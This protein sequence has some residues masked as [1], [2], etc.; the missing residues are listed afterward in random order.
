MSS[1]S[2]KDLEGFTGIKAHTL[3][4]WEKRYHVLKPQR[5]STNIRTYDD[6]DLKRILNISILNRHGYRISDIIKLSEK[7]ICEKV[8]QLSQRCADTHSQIEN[9][10]MA[11]IEMDE[12]I[13]HQSFNQSVLKS[14]FE[15]TFRYLI[16]PFFER[17]GLLWQSGSITPAQEHFVSNLIRQKLIVAIDSI[18]SPRKPN[19]LHFVLFLPEGE[20]HEI[21]LLFT[22]YLIKKWG[23]YTLYF[24]TNLPIETIQ[25]V[26]EKFEINF[27]VTQF[28]NGICSHDLN[29][30]IQKLA[31]VSQGKKVLLSGAQILQKQ[32]DIPSHFYIYEDIDKLREIIDIQH[33]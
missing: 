17:V 19:A 25:P 3:R 31:E 30:Q 5:T 15:D 18:I 20:W 27:V 23:H 26:L 11:M 29:G 4:I 16:F 13:F 7:E 21:G 2:I 8:M 32:F 10:L 28:I 14:G 24:G 22:Y 9:L 12:E 6:E 1:Y 33:V